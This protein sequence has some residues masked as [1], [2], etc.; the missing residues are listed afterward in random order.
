MLKLYYADATLFKQEGVFEHL[1]EQ[2][3]EQRRSKVL[4]CKNAEDKQCSLLAGVLLRY[5][6]EQLG[7]DYEQLE[8]DATPEG[9]PYI[10]NVRDLYFSLSHS[11]K[12]A[13]CLVSDQSIGVDI[14]WK[15]RRQLEQGQEKRLESIAEKC[16]S[17]NELQEYLDAPDSMKKEVFLRNWTRKEAFSKAVGKGLAMDFAKIEEEDNHF[18]SFWLEEYYLSIY[19]K[20]SSARKDLEIC[21]MS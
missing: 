11:G 21:M 20:E 7:Y 13:V 17:K 9:K 2:V 15:Y 3:N 18:L 19:V 6:L 10:K 14:E 4:R 8:F 16:F 12:F 5:A 1:L